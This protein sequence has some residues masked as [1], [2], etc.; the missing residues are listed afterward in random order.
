MENHG[1]GKG[2]AIRQQDNEGPGVLK[3][4]HH[5]ELKK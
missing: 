3:I 2:E 1:R 5:K 4:D